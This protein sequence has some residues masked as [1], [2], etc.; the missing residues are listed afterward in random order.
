[1]AALSTGLLAYQTGSQF[2]GQRD[3]A[4]AALASGSYQRSASNQ[5][6]A[7]ADAQAADAV[8]RGNEAAAREVGATRQAMGA[9]RAA[10]GGSGTN[11]NGGSAADVAGETS[12]V[13]ALDALTLQNNAAREAWGYRVE[14]QQ[15]RNAGEFAYR[16]GRNTASALRA[17]AW[18]TLLTGAA[19]GF[20]SYQSRSDARSMSVPSAPR[21]GYNLYRK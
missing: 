5:N 17:G 6:A 15:E 10:G 3:Q 18:G 12:R 7:L 19:Q 8:Q 4:N 20:Q 16:A 11:L 13:G 2:F 1:M 9:A 21:G 14:G